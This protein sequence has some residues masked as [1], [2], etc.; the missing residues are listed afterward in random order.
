MSALEHVWFDLLIFKMFVDGPQFV[1]QEG[2]PRGYSFINTLSRKFINTLSRK[3]IN[4]NVL[5]QFIRKHR[6]N[7]L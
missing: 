5:A 2:V 4:T 7:I 3:F 1:K 6:Q